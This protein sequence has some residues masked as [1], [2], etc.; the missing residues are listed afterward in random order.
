M[1]V[2]I[3]QEHKKNYDQVVYLAS[4][5]VPDTEIARKLNIGHSF[6]QKTT[7]IYW[8]DKMKNKL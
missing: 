4:K 6:V 1:G 2:H 3:K 7:T 8:N 5:G